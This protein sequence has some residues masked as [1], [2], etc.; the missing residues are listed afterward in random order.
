MKQAML[1]DARPAATPLPL[2]RLVVF[3]QTLPAVIRERAL[4]AL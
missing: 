3:N 2:T 4:L 1:I